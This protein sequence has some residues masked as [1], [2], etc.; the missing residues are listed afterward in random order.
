MSLRLHLV[1]LD[2]V[3]RFAG[4]WRV[5]PF[6]PGLNVLAAPNEA[7]KSTL[8]AAI[9]AAIFLPHRSTADE[10]RALRREGGGHPEIALTLETDDGPWTIRKRFAGPS[11]R[12]ELVAPTG[13]SFAG[14]AAEEEIRRLF[15]VAP[16]AGRREVPRG[17]WGALWVTQGASFAQPALDDP[18]RATLNDALA[19]Q[20]G[21]VTG[22]AGARRINDTIAKELTRLQTGTGRP[23]GDLKRALDAAQEAKKR[24]DDLAKRRDNVDRLLEEVARLRAERQRRLAERNEQ[25]DEEELETARREHRALED[26]ASRRRAAEEAAAQAARLVEAAEEARRHRA[27]L[28]AETDRRAADAAKAERDHAAAEARRDHA[29]AEAASAR[30]AHEAA[31]QAVAAAEEACARNRARAA[32]PRLA[33]DAAEA[34]RRATGWGRDAAVGGRGANGLALR[35]RAITERP[36][37]KSLPAAIQA[38]S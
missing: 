10:S 7:G 31:R 28:V 9:H 13:R 21:V 20:V 24:R 1:E 12:A 2:G 33:A 32:L 6:S 18:A 27:A 25:R 11:G 19:A 38:A 22:G 35:A 16:S 37:G 15:G 36:N 29:M 30:A 3:R 4:R 5:G 34:R 8:L 17:V 23:T 26:A 14:D